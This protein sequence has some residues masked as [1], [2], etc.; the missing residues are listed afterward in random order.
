[1]ALGEVANEGSDYREFGDGARV[2]V[3]AEDEEDQGFHPRLG[4]LEGKDG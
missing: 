1:M 3:I 2:G 4:F